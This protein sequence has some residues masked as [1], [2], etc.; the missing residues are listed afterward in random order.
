M[1][2]L[3]GKIK[4][5]YDGNKG[6][7]PHILCDKKNMLLVLKNHVFLEKQKK[8]MHID[9]PCYVIQAPYSVVLSVY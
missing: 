5:K 4:H 1:N 8:M 2:V 9:I 7:I 6:N 3:L